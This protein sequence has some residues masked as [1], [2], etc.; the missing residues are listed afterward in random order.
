MCRWRVAG[1][2]RNKNN[3]D[4]GGNGGMLEIKSE[5]IRLFLLWNYMSA[6]GGEACGGSV[7]L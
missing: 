6:V 2:L 3:T 4:R 1:R 5:V 7:L